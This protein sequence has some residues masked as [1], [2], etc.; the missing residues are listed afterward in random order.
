MGV[1][2]SSA[3]A[4]HTTAPAASMVDWCLDDAEGLYFRL[5]ATAQ[6]VITCSVSGTDTVA[7][8]VRRLLIGPGGLP[9][10]AVPPAS[11][12]AFATALPGL[13][14]DWDEGGGTVGDMIDRLLSGTGGVLVERLDGTLAIVRPTDVTTGPAA[15]DLERRHLVRGR[16]AISRV[17]TTVP[18][19]AVEFGYGHL[20]RTFDEGTIAPAE[21]ASLG[22]LRDA[23]QVARTEDAV[24]KARYPTSTVLKVTSRLADRADAEALAARALALEERRH[25]P[26]AATLAVDDIAGLEL[27]DVVR[28]ATGRLGHDPEYWTIVGLTLTNQRTATLELW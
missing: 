3:A 2:R 26:I 9:E 20:W 8:L 12:D 14:G 27:G 5:G 23:D 11:F 1:Q 28:N 18:H 6:G 7:A 13:A 16:S 25:Q 19:Y 22:G 17:A 10:S 24:L 4:L 15:F 21:L